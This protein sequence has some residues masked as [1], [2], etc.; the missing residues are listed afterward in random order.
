MHKS[1]RTYVFSTAE[2]RTGFS[3]TGISV[4]VSWY[5]CSAVSTVRLYY[6]MCYSNRQIYGRVGTANGLCGN[7]GVQFEQ[8]FYALVQ[9]VE[10]ETVQGMLTYVSHI[11]PYY[12]IFRNYLV[13]S[14]IFQKQSVQI[15]MKSI[16]VIR[17]PPI[18]EPG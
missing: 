3:N 6:A 10:R 14:P 8:P 15:W 4:F 17:S 11:F 12:S 9:N 16:M 7:D 18:M 13:I 5:P 1:E 2:S